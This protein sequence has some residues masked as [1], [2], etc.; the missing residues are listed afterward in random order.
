M[1]SW[2]VGLRG[3]GFKGL[4]VQEAFTQYPFPAWGLEFKD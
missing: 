3:S 1:A 4:R 2:G